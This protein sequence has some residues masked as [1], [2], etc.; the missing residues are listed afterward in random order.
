MA[1]KKEASAR[2]KAYREEHREELIAYSRAYNKAH[3][4]THKDADTKEYAEKK[5]K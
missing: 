5:K 4:N 2:S 1:H 3:R